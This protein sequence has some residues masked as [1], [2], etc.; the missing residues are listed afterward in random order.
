MI[1]TTGCASYFDEVLLV[2][3]AALLL[4]HGAD[5]NAIDYELKTTPLGYAAYYGRPRYLKFLLSRGADASPVGSESEA[6]PLALA[7]NSPHAD[8]AKLLHDHLNP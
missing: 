4:E 1:A 8:C 5:I 6:K 7:E 2:Q 3:F